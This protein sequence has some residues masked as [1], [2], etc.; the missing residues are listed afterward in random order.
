[1]GSMH[2]V[3]SFYDT[4]ALIR[5]MT[6]EDTSFS[7]LFDLGTYT[8]RDFKCLLLTRQIMDPSFPS[9]YYP[10]IITPFGR[11][12]NGTRKQ[13]GYLTKG[14]GLCLQRWSWIWG[15]AAT[16]Q[17]LPETPLQRHP[18]SLAMTYMIIHHGDKS[19]LGKLTSELMW[20][21]LKT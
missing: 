12:S 8:R 11:F 1:M 16:K 7:G 13:P 19:S 6:K 2:R 15:H 14:S 10:C 17:L 4:C 20:C 9:F 21:G 5:A 3:F 18:W